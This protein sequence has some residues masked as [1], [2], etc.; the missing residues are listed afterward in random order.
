MVKL[1]LASSQKLF[2]WPI[3]RWVAAPPPSVKIGGALVVVGESS[4]F[5]GNHFKGHGVED[6]ER[7]NMGIIDVGTKFRV[8]HL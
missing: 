4:G 5:L 7:E 1:V 3:V 6:S 2:T 8:K